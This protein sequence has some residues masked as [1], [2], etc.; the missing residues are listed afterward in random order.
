M[1]AGFKSNAPLAHMQRARK[2]TFLRAI[3]SQFE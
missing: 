2:A 1:V 3:L